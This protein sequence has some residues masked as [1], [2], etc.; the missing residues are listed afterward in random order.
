MIEGIVPSVLA[1]ILA[2]GSAAG[3]DFTP[4]LRSNPS[5]RAVSPGD[6]HRRRIIDDP[7]CWIGRF[8]ESDGRLCRRQYRP[9]TMAGSEPLGSRRDPRCGAPKK[10]RWPMST[11]Q[12]RRIA[13]GSTKW[14]IRCN[15]HLT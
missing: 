1:T 8:A 5:M 7:L 14:L 4:P 10:S 11:P 15:L 13:F 2:A 12:W 9:K 3:Q 6:S